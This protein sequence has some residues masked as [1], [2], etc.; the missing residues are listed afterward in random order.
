MFEIPKFASGY[1]GG[2]LCIIKRTG[3]DIIIF[4]PVWQRREVTE[5]CY[6]GLQRLIE[7]S[8][9]DYNIKVFIT[10]SDME[11]AQLA[12]KYGWEYTMYQNLPLGEKFNFGMQYVFENYE[13]D[14]I[15]QMNSDNIIDSTIWEIF[16]PYLDRNIPVAGID[17]LYFYDSASKKIYFFRY[18]GGCGIRFIHREVIGNSGF[19]IHVDC[20]VTAANANWTFRQG[21]DMW[22]PLGIFN[23][24]LHQ[25]LNED[26]IFRLWPPDANSGLDDGSLTLI[27]RTSKKY[28]PMRIPNCIPLVVDI[29]SEENIHTIDEFEQVGELQM[30]ND[31]KEILKRFPEL[32]HFEQR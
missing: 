22:I 11:D 23:K 21:K 20:K 30:G 25:T 6:K 4:I 26:L 28:Y 14:Y 9:T 15:M 2:Y 12:E 8:P 24:S 5:Q 13:F 17:K 27:Y 7:H 3:M 31:R 16:H 10:A 1:K 18:P 29:K 32:E 19:H